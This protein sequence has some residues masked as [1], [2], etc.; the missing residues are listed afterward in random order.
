[1]P[2]SN[3]PIEKLA[4]GAQLHDQMNRMLVL[5][6]ALEFHNVWL[7]GQMVH[8]LDFP[9]DILNVLLVDQLPLGYRFAGELLSGLFVGAQMGHSELASAELFPDG[10]ER[11]SSIGRPKTG[12]SGA[13]LERLGEAGGGVGLEGEGGWWGEWLALSAFCGEYSDFWLVVA[14]AAVELSVVRPWEQQFPIAEP[15]KGRE[16][17]F[18]EKRREEKR[19]RGSIIRRLPSMRVRKRKYKKE[20]ERQKKEDGLKDALL[21]TYENCIVIV[22]GELAWNGKKSRLKRVFVT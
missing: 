10:V 5:K 20:T 17:G 1:M 12:P 16:G 9:P 19:R 15:R 13:G 6:G 18:E 22:R 2:F 21:A 3:D 4:A 11:T 8:D 14:A 7:T